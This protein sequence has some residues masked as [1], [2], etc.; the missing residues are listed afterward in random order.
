M[1]KKSYYEDWGFNDTVKIFLKG[2]PEN[3]NKFYSEF[4]KI[5]FKEQIEKNSNNSVS[6]WVYDSQIPNVKK[7]GKLFDLKVTFENG[8]KIDQSVAKV[9]LEQLG[10]AGR[11]VVMTG[12]NNFISFSNGV[13]FKIKN[14]KVNYVKIV[15]NGKDLYDVQFGRIAVGK[16]KIIAEHNDIYFDQLIPI[17]EKETGMYLRLFSKGGKIC[18]ENKNMILTQLK[19][20]HHH[21]EE[22]LKILEESGEIESWVLAKVQRANTDLSDV[23]HYLDGKTKFN[24]GGAI[25]PFKIEVKG[26]EIYVNG[27]KA[28]VKKMYLDY[29]NNFLT[30]QAFADYYN[31]SKKQALLII[32]NGRKYA[33]VDGYFR[34]GGLVSNYFDIYVNDDW[35]NKVY[36]TKNI[37]L[38]KLWV[39]KRWKKYDVIDVID[40][41]GDSIRVTKTDDINDINWLFSD[42]YAKGGAVRKL[43]QSDAVIYKDETW[44]V[45]EKNGVI[46]ITNFSRGAWGS[47]YPFIPL[48]KL[49]LSIV[50]DMYGNN[51]E[52]G[53]GGEV[54]SSFSVADTNPYIAGAKAVQGIAPHSVSALDKKLARKLNPDPN[55]PVFFAFGGKIGDIVNFKDINGNIRSGTITEQLSDGNFAVSTTFGQA[56][57]NKDNFISYGTI[58]TERKKFLG[59]FAKGGKLSKYELFKEF[60]EKTKN[61][62]ANQSFV[63]MQEL[64]KKNNLSFPEYVSIIHSLA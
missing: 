2:E 23:T 28:D 20:I 32:E 41:K 22:L 53:K 60:E 54:G 44:Y 12:A 51:V 4:K 11:L 58:P 59:I 29:V 37:E 18:N 19:S 24:L 40:D 8:G 34:D 6:V 57:V 21:E 10:G 14:R 47:D 64:A 42:K 50:T 13:S 36:H 52:F 33:E 9:I 31:I 26:N 25:K 46:G 17:F 49:N 55:R 27:T 45:T 48:S 16:L 39:L 56:L 3:V 38:A 35:D 62:H 15:L 5:H 1:P 61:K 30:V 63:I 7:L 43:Q